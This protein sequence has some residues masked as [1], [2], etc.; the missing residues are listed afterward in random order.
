MATYAVVYSDEDNWGVSRDR[1][2]TRA[3]ADRRVE[4]ARATG[5]LVRLVRW[6]DNIPTEV[7][8]LMPDAM[9]ADPTSNDW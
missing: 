7:L 6:E 3:E 1:F 5:R 2:K 4:E 9:D 8:R